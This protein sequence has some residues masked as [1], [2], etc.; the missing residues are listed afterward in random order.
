[1]QTRTLIGA[2]L[3][4]GVL[5]ACT[6]AAPAGEPVAAETVAPEPEAEAPEV[7][8]EEE[9]SEADLGRY[10]TEQ[11][12]YCCHYEVMTYPP[13]LGIN[14]ETTTFEPASNTARGLTGNVTFSLL[15]MPEGWDSPTHPI[16][17]QGENGLTYD[18]RVIEDGGV[19]AI[20]T[21]DWSDIML[22]PIGMEDYLNEVTEDPG[23]V[24]FVF[25][26][27]KSSEGED[28]PGDHPCMTDRYVALTAQR[29]GPDKDYLSVAMFGDEP[30][31]ATE[32][33][34]CGG[35]S[36]APGVVSPRD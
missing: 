26:V 27:I 17:M 23:T 21:L 13:P 35:Y 19:N 8:I 34:F 7:S 9:E 31:P 18:L 15:P 6:Q 11:G 29:G 28:I 33:R 25:E 14:G 30:W 3:A 1:M 16:R 12:M 22:R 5:A 24:V 10:W 20:G 36:Y 32:D 4:L 2:L